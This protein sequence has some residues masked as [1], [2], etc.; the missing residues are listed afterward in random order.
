MR[1]TQRGEGRHDR[2]KLRDFEST[3]KREVLLVDKWQNYYF[4]GFL[5]S[6][7]LVIA[8]VSFQGEFVVL[9]HVGYWLLLHGTVDSDDVVQH[10]LYFIFQYAGRLY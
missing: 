1:S 5:Q 6:R 8:A 9:S 4:N 2:F 10:T 7:L 3:G